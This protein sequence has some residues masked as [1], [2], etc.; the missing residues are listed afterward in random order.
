MPSFY[1]VLQYLPDPLRGECVNFGVITYNDRGARARFLRSWR[2]ISAFG[3][4]DITF[5]RDFAKSVD[6]AIDSQTL[7]RLSPDAPERPQLD[8]EKLESM[9]S[10]WMNSIQLT[11]ARASLLSPD[12]LLASIAGDFLYEPERE[13]RQARSRLHA[14]QLAYDALRNAV[15][16]RVPEPLARKVVQHGREIRGHAEPHRFDASLGNGKALAAALGVSFETKEERDQEAYVTQAAWS[17]AD[18]R[19][20][21]PDLPL[22]LFVIPPPGGD[23]DPFHRA[24]IIARDL[25]VQVVKEGQKEAWASRAAAL[26]PA[27]LINGARGG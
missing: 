12:A 15:T 8:A 24:R 3:G 14:G 6:Q 1:S 22:T 21:L 25:D 10:D 4:E 11:P 17:F 16:F 26:L 7:L 9:A 27:D 13:H 5:L 18:V 19:K 2:R 20:V 23:N